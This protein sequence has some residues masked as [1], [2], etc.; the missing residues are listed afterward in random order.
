[1]TGGSATLPRPAEDGFGDDPRIAP[2]RQSALL[3]PAFLVIAIG[4]S[5]ALFDGGFLETV[6]YPVA[7][8]VLALFVLVLFLAPPAR[9]ERSRTFDLA[10]ALFGLFMLF[11]YASILW[12]DVPADAWMGANR[13]LLYWLVFMLVGLRPWAVPAARLAVM[14][15]GFG[16]AGVAA[17]FLLITAADDTPSSMFLLGRLSEPT[18]YAN[19]TAN[20]WLIGVWPAL[21]VAL[22]PT[23]RWPVRALGLGAAALLLQTALMSQ[24]RG[25]V[26]GA[27]V[28]AVA[29]VLLHPRHWGALAALAVPF[30]SLALGW[31]TLTGMRDAETTAQLDDAFVDARRWIL[32]ATLIVLAV[33]A[34]GAFA[35]E[36]VR[37]RLT[38]DPSRRRMASLAFYISAGLVALT[39]C[40]VLAASTGWI[41]AR[42]DDFR[43]MSYEADDGT[44]S[45][46]T[47]LDSSRYDTYRVSIN[48]FRDHPVAGIGAENFAVPYLQDRRTAEAPR[49]AHSLFFTLISSLG[50]VGTLLFA[51]FLVTAGVAA[52]RVRLR[53][54]PPAQEVV[55]GALVATIA[56]L[57]HASVDWLY[58]WPALAIPALAMLAVAART[59][60]R[61][62][63]TS[64]GPVE[65]VRSLPARAVVGVLVVVAG[66]SLVLPAAG[67][68]YERSA[69]RVA[70]SDPET[71]I[72]RLGSAA[73][74]DPLDAD[75]LVAQAIFARR[76]GDVE[77]ARESLAEAIEREHLNWFA[78]F[79]VALLEGEARNWP[80]AEQAVRR[81]EELN[82][83]QELV[84]E[85]RELIAERKRIDAT[86]IETALGGQLSTR[87]R[88][89]FLR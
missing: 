66:V 73:D 8:F 78:H 20:L 9:S 76:S 84:H 69:F 36:R 44:G 56:W 63:V 40:G 85:V 22:T 13:T 74:V 4:I 1:M 54:S 51:G 5:L 60:D 31:D 24:S 89:L 87:L 38:P 65:W 86:E 68:R 58:E 10:A 27:S 39:L 72:N 57:A 32:V 64:S 79:E 61:E 81:A 37:R 11:S 77:K 6:W 33:G 3:A 48:L 53:G 23:L 28:A 30:V 49:Y 43:E 7:L 42:W 25:W 59:T 55:V 45:R 47:D 15:V 34:V 18:G 2:V 50:L 82:P 16:L 46:F 21:Y 17:G 41:D 35:D 70:A 83:R 80:A 26:L 52:M 14:L 12:A 67:A 29:F 19:A 88:S 62:G 71:A 75:P